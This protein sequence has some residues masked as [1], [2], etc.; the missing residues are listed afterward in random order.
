MPWWKVPGWWS[1]ILTVAVLLLGGQSGFFQAALGLA[2]RLQE[3]ETDLRSVEHDIA[4][5]KA[6]QAK[7]NAERTNWGVLFD[8][9]LDEVEKEDA[10]AEEWRSQTTRRLQRIE[11]AVR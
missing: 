2:S 5:I 6:E 4:A 3:I 7:E 9:R 1:F 8:N 11:Q 10:R